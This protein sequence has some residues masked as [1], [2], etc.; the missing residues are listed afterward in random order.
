MSTYMLF[1]MPPWSG[2]KFLHDTENEIS[3]IEFIYQEKHLMSM[4][5]LVRACNE[6]IKKSKRNDTIVCAYDLMGVLCWWLCKLQFKKRNIIAINILLKTKNTLKNRLL[7]FLYR[8]ALKSKSFHA[9]VTTEE[10]GQWINKQLATSCKYALL[11]DV[12]RGGYNEYSE[13][14]EK[15]RSVFCGGRNG[16]NWKLLAQIAE[17]MPDTVFNFAMPQ[18][19]YE[20]YKS[21]FGENVNAK[22]DIPENE[23]A[24]LMLESELMVMPLDTEAP[25]GLIVL[26][27]AAGNGKLIITSNTVTTREYFGD[28]KGALCENNV[29]EWVDQIRYWQ[30]HPQE[31]EHNAKKCRTFLENEC[32]ERKY[33]EVLMQVIQNVNAGV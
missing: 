24:K 30:N 14:K 28:G 27:H 21:R 18:Q 17:K 3:K 4:K 31:A 33:A 9:T 12:Y 25:A 10:Y 7:K 6:C 15:T 8:A 2:W 20:E 13:I 22:F 19:C 16:R 11:H 5:E 26:F 29:D 23:F 1:N 32:S